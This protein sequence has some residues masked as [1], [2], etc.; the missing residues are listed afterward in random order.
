L[1][2]S[3]GQVSS[4]GHIGA[5]LLLKS[6]GGLLLGIALAWVASEL[7]RRVEASRNWIFSMSRST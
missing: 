4:I 7:M 3:K 6:G 2:A 1:A 5:L